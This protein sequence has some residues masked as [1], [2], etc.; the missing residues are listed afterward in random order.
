MG[1]AYDSYDYLSYWN[2]RKYEHE[3]EVYALRCFLD[4]I[5]KIAKAIELGGGFGR[6]APYYLF[7]AKTVTL[8]DPSAKLLS[9]ARKQL[10]AYSNMKYV[11]T[12]LENA[13]NKFRK[14]SFDL[15]LTV[16]VL[17]HIPNV[18]EAFDIIEYL[19]E[20]NGHVIFEFANKMH[21]KAVISH[22]L[23]GDF[24]FLNDTNSIDV[25]SA[26]S[27][28]AKTLPFL[29]HHPKAIEDELSKHG[30]EVVQKRSVSN[31]RSV[32]AKKH[33]PIS[34]LLWVEKLVQI[35]FAYLNFGPSIFILARKKG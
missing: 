35:P 16:R 22:L 11:Q 17:H 34:V 24:K 19:V 30:F 5:P 32:S 2:E 12:S 6:L 25:R 15:V 27:I 8:T 18:S 1:A 14:G 7:R 4:R 13:K 26:E 3:S 28:K 9:I 20:P 33:I 21:G 29:N 10:S 31:I 23:K